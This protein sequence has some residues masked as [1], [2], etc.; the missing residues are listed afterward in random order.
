MHS[1]RP[2][3]RHLELSIART[4]GALR[5]DSI[6]SKIVVFA[7]LATLIPAVSTAVFSYVQ[8]KG[9]LTEK[10]NEEL[11]AVS[12]QAAREMD[13]WIKERVFD[14]RV[15]SG[16]FQVSENLERV[17]RAGRSGARSLEALARLNEYLGSVQERFPDYEELLVLDPDGNV[18]A[19]GGDELGEVQLPDGWLEGVLREQTFLGQPYWDDAIGKAVVMTAVPIEATGGER[20]L[21]G[22]LSG[23]VNFDAVDSVLQRFAPSESARVYVVT[24]G[25]S[26]ITTSFASSKEIMQTRIDPTTLVALEEAGGATT[27]YRDEDGVTVVGTHNR[28]P[29]VDWAV[30]A[31]V[32]RS[33][34][35]AP[36][37]R[38]RNFALVLVTGLLIVVGAIAYI[39]GLLI[40]RPLARLTKGAA[41][42]A[43]GDLSVDLPVVGGGEVGYLTEVFNDMV[44]RLREGREALDAANESLRKKNEELQRLSITDG[45]T[46]LYNRRHLME[47]L[48]SERR[49]ADRSQRTFAILMVDVD[50]FKK[51]NDRFGH[52][53]GDEVLLRVAG[54]LRKCTRD[55]D[56]AGRYGGEEFCL[57]LSESTL[58]GAVEVG[59]RIRSELAAVTFEGDRVTVSVGAAEYPTD[60][61]SVEAVLSS[62]DAALYQAKRKGRDRVIPA[63]RRKPRTSKQ[64]V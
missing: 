33:E 57:L 64:D 63:P 7:L 50:H 52:Q 43:G 28:V 41:E 46:G 55:V 20:E 38:L 22:V 27:E 24:A 25:G 9:A 17:R 54:I 13:I 5:L 45:L 8:N 40:V 29:R 10:L 23:K 16:S 14:V 19:S 44:T 58:E 39:L 31:Q 26:I 2:T 36:V 42:V 56:F 51:F 61:Q 1:L 47:T 6:K 11:S 48:D 12:R 49:R 53:A 30:V 35:Y 21:L 60:G 3:L 62:A 18:V 15:F 59:E 32:P 37:R 4:S 34:A